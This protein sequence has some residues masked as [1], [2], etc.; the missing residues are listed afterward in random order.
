MAEI[1]CAEPQGHLVNQIGLSRSYGRG[2][3]ESIG[4]PLSVEAIHIPESV[5]L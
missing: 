2:V 1:H 5:Y 3:R 4:I